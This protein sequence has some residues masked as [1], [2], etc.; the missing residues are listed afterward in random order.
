M[1]SVILE[2]RDANGTLSA[3]S[4]GDEL[5]DEMCSLYATPDDIQRYAGKTAL[6]PSELFLHR[7]GLVVPR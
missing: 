5:G 1:K 7:F 6:T 3:Y 4:I 2:T